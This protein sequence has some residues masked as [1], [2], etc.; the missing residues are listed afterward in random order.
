MPD[1]RWYYSIHRQQH[2]PVTL[3]ELRRL[4]ETGALQASA[5]IWHE[6]LP[7]WTPAEAVDALRPAGPPPLPPPVPGSGPGSGPEP[8]IRPRTLRF[9]APSAV[10]PAALPKAGPPSMPSVPPLPSST[11]A[12]A[13]PRALPVPTTPPSS[14][15]DAVVGVLVLCGA[16]VLA[17]LAAATGS[18]GGATLFMLVALVGTI[19]LY[20]R[21]ATFLFACWNALPWKHRR[22]SPLLAAFSLFIPIANLFLCFKSIWGLSQQTN[23]ALR[24]RGLR[25]AAPEQ[26]GLAVSIGLVLLIA[27]PLALP[28]PPFSLLL[29]LAYAALLGIWLLRQ[30]HATDLLL[31][32]PDP[33]P[34]LLGWMIALGGAGTLALCLAAFSV[35]SLLRNARVAPSPFTGY[36]PQDAEPD[37]DSDL[38]ALIQR[39]RQRNAS[40]SEELNNIRIASQGGRIYWSRPPWDEQEAALRRMIEQEAQ[41]NRQFLRQLEAMRGAYGP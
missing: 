24:E 3:A 26:L 23:A 10:P 37:Q 32:H 28:A 7:N 1:D 29:N 33:G 38:V 39:E 15:M 5:L 36:A 6:S 9:E 14:I 18:S 13:P 21:V 40:F 25:P 19:V 8:K 27:L 35:A 22:M 4:R 31:G 2:G 30:C 16:M 12:P 41:R 34:P 17:T 20:V 11:P